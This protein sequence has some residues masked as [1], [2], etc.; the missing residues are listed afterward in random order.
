MWEDP[1]AVMVEASYCNKN[2]ISSKCP[3]GPEEFLSNGKGGYLFQNKNKKDLVDKINIFLK[4]NEKDRFSKIL[5]CK[6]K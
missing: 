2:V 6:K 3:N 5:L 1:G 4:D